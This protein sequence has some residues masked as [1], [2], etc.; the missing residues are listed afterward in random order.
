MSDAM[1][2]LH[3]HIQEISLAG[4]DRHKCTLQLCCGAVCVAGV[5]V[6]T[7][8]LELYLQHTGNVQQGG[9]CTAV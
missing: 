1:L 9:K 7:H 6:Q 3:R 2:L 8:H 5:V 4:S